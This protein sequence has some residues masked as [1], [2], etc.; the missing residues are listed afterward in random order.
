V[1]LK[2]ALKHREVAQLVEQM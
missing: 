1:N 2:T